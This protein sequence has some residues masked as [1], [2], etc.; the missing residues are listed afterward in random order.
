MLFINDKNEY[1]RYI[2]DIQAEYPEWLP[3]DELPDGWLEVADTEVPL[4]TLDQV[5]VEEF[6]EEVD[7]VLTRKFTVRELNDEEKAVRE[8]PKR[9]VEKL[10]ALG[11]TE[12]E[13][14]ALLKLNR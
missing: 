12:D 14:R 3:G 9:A 10:V 4:P 8:A 13:V 2:G 7:G 6:P 11:L 1:P 5:I